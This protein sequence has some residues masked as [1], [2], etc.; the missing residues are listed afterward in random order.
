MVIFISKR[1]FSKY[2]KGIHIIRLH[3]KKKGLMFLLKV[4]I[5]MTAHTDAMRKQPAS[6]HRLPM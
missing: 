3:Y 6:V 4:K 1:I 2:I 5:A